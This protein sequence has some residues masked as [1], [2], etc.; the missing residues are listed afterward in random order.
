MLSSE[1]PMQAPDGTMID[2]P[3]RG[4]AWI[5]PAYPNAASARRLVN[6]RRLESVCAAAPRPRNVRITPP[7]QTA[8]N[9][10]TLPA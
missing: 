4:I 6:Q 5:R 1:L 9:R 2:K 10:P 3:E 8:D 7:L